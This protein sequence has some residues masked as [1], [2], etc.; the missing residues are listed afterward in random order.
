MLH[1]P[2]ELNIIKRINNDTVEKIKIREY[3]DVYDYSN[4]NIIEEVTDYI[5]SNHIGDNDNTVSVEAVLSLRSPFDR[6]ITFPVESYMVNIAYC[7]ALATG[8]AIKSLM[9]RKENNEN[10]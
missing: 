8:E 3:D 1:N 6:H 5:I 2:L 7:K 4:I 10:G 9:R